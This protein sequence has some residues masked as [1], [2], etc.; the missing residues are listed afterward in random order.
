[1]DDV[2][3]WTPMA[4]VNTGSPPAAPNYTYTHTAVLFL[5]FFFFMKVF[6]PSQL[7][8]SL[9]FSIQQ[10]PA[11]S[12]VYIHI[13]TVRLK[14]KEKICL[15]VG[16]APHIFPRFQLQIYRCFYSQAF[17]LLCL[18]FSNYIDQRLD[19]DICWAPYIVCL[20][21]NPYR[22]P[23]SALKT[24][25]LMLAPRAANPRTQ[26]SLW[27]ASV[28]VP[29]GRSLNALSDFSFRYLSII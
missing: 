27:N 10:R 3:W 24:E 20:P 2:C 22:F 11:F 26:D 18:F 12:K 4:A 29:A 5:L 9:C 16:G 13:C 6:S 14:V 21:T 25:M 7:S 28:C 19:D 17:T 1:M 23:M 8:S 15:M